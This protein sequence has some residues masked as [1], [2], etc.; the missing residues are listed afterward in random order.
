MLIARRCLSGEPLCRAKRTDRPVYPPQILP[1][2]RFRLLARPFRQADAQP[3]HRHGDNKVTP[4]PM[5]AFF[6]MPSGL[7]ES[8]R[9]LVPFCFRIARQRGTGSLPGYPHGSLTTSRIYHRRIDTE[10]ALS[11]SRPGWAP[12]LRI[13][14]S[15]PKKNSGVAHRAETSQGRTAHRF[16]GSRGDDRSPVRSVS[17]KIP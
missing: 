12:T 15:R 11:G 8:A 6:T 2:G 5:I 16:N 10:K 4:F 1:A 3:Q 17:K 14:S 7:D 13:S 9:A